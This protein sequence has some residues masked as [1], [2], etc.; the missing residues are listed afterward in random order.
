[1]R[2]EAKHSFFKHLARVIHNFKNVP[3]TVALR[4]QNYM[5][6]HLYNKKTYLQASHEYS[7]GIDVLYPIT[8]NTPLTL[9]NPVTVG[10]LEF[11]EQLLI[12]V[13][14]LTEDSIVHL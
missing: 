10:S 3:K 5:C 14:E 12:A 2:Y 8:F 7:S 6:L 9:G 4:H 13:S 11:S 1:M